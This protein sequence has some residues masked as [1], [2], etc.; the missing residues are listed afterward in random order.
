MSHLRSGNTDALIIH[1]SFGDD[2]YVFV[3]KAREF[4]ALLQKEDE[5]PNNNKNHNDTLN[6]N[7]NNHNSGSGSGRRNHDAQ[8]K[9]KED[10][11]EGTRNN[12]TQ[13]GTNMTIISHLANQFHEAVTVT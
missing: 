7:N 10:Q 8:E 1:K 12:V 2:A 13:P 11:K 5:Y 9:V 4:L 3:E 6:H